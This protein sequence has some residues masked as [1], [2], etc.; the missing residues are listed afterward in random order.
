MNGRHRHGQFGHHPLDH[1]ARGSHEHH[2]GFRG[3]GLRI[4]R[5][6][7]AADLQLII[8]ALLED[9][10]RHGYDLIKAI[11]DLAAGAYTPSP[12][13]VYPALSYLEE[14]GQ[15]A[16]QLD[17]TKKTYR[18][19]ESGLTTLNE[20]RARVSKLFDALTRAGERLGEAREAYERTENASSPRGQSPTLGLETVRRDL[21]SVLFDSLDASLEE[22]QRI[23]EILQRTIAEIRNK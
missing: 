15:V 11:A 7:S 3:G 17:G 22:Q 12:G 18:L 10:P 21:K 8:V 16:L 2:G 14:L 19:T 13:V 6:L 9:R 5:M 4:G 20:S 1:R 23:V